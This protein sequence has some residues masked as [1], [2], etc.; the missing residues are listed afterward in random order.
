MFSYLV[1]DRVSLANLPIPFNEYTEANREH[2]L[3]TIED[4]LDILSVS[5]VFS[6]QDKKRLQ[7]VGQ[8]VIS[9][10]RELDFYAYA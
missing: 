10:E 1:E 6:E 8:E 3:F 9:L 2:N 5:R 7:L 4:G